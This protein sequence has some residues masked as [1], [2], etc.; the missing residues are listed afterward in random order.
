M[1][2]VALHLSP[3]ELG[4]G[5]WCGSV[6]SNSVP[7]E[8]RLCSLNF[9]GVKGVGLMVS[10]MRAW[11]ERKGLMDEVA[12][13]V[14]AMGELMRAVEKSMGTDSSISKSLAEQEGGGGVVGG[15]LR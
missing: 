9:E 8:S 11:L 10:S 7:G 6:L 2:E 1:G 12:L 4:E 13:P 14:N 3:A 15:E 5:E